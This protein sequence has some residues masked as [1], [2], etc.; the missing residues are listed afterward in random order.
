MKRTMVA[1]A[2]PLLLVACQKDGGDLGKDAASIGS[3][4]QVLKEASAA[5]NEVIRNA[6]DCDAVKA[7]L[8]ETNRKL[9]EAAG[10]VR[11]APGRATLDSLKTQVR[12]IAQ[13]CP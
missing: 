9:D 12:G 6:T 2:L 7:A 13:N 3:D 8:S 11:T 1:L 5:A 4:T 10:R